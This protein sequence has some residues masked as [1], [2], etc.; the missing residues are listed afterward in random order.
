MSPK[1]R[2]DVGQIFLSAANPSD[3]PQS[4]LHDA[5]SALWSLRD[6]ALDCFPQKRPIVG[7]NV[8]APQ[9]IILAAMK[10]ILKW[11]CNEKKIPASC[12]FSMPVK[13]P[14]G[15]TAHCYRPEEVQA[16]IA[17]CHSIVNFVW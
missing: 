8:Y 2:G 7:I 16:M 15:T 3:D 17:V 11:L 1:A 6:P 10:Q 5:L 13:K 14:Q 9:R 12:L 4:Q